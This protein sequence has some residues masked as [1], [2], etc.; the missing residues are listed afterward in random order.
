MRIVVHGPLVHPFSRTSVHRIID[1]I[2]TV[3]CGLKA[4]FSIVSKVDIRQKS[5]CLY[6]CYFKR[7]MV[8]KGQVFA[9][10]LCVS[11]KPQLS[12]KKAKIFTAG[13][14]REVLTSFIFF[15]KLED[16]FTNFNQPQNK[17]N[18]SL[19]QRHFCYSAT[20]DEKGKKKLSL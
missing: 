3:P 15:N 1:H 17:T 8:E 16:R 18:C 11:W 20:F 12:P 4:L 7:K 14:C 9:P 19:S 5:Y 6:V 13:H 2:E 10:A